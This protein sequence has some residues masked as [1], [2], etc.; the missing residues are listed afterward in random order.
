M[1]PRPLHLVL[2]ATA[3]FFAALIPVL[4]HR[5]FDPDEFEHAHA[6]WL[7][8]KGMVPYKDFFEHHTPWYYYALRPLFNWFDVDASF[9]G[10]RH[11]LV[12]GRGLSLLV[13]AVSLWLVYQIG[14]R[15]AARGIGLVAALLLLTQ[16]VFF[17]KAVELRGDVLALP[18]F[19]A[20]LLALVRGL[21]PRV[22]ARG[23]A[24]AL[25][26]FVGAGLAVGG[27]VM[28]TQKMLFVL[29]GALAGL[30]LWALTAAPRT[31]ARVRSRILA[32]VAFGLALGVPL[33]LT[34]AAFARQDAGHEFIRNN[35]LL[36]AGWK[37]FATKQLR[38]VL[39][40]SAPVL[41]LAVFGMKTS[42]S[43]LLRSPSAERRYGDLLLACMAV[44]PFAE[45]PLVPAAH[46]QYYMMPLPILCLFAARAL[47]TLAERA[48]ARGRSQ[49]FAR[50]LPLLAVLPLI[51]LIGELNDSNSRQLAKLRTVFERTAPADLVMDGWQGMGVFRPHAF[52]YYFLH[53]E[54]RAMLPPARLDAFLDD[55][56]SGRVR[57]KLIVLDTNLRELGPRFVSFV[58]SHYASNDDFFY[59][60]NGATN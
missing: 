7:M 23:P 42:L 17:Q 26:W 45:L 4:P 12:A 28:C 58:Q 18:F 16:P 43:E 59:F 25:G 5:T 20:G 3:G 48:R 46:R 30:G 55:L 1:R 39:L 50:A 57:P 51:S 49:Q 52:Y 53:E 15:W 10:A 9:D 36:N 33:L 37:H 29:P 21:E 34:W 44:A 19:L 41:A 54:T 2:A 8:W 31:S 56:E 6:A 40:T 13:T 32:I 24:G 27:A 14:R 11:F 35:F 38:K 22:E 47:F 60:A